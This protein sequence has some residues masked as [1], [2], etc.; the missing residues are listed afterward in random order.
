M[1]NHLLVGFAFIASALYGAG[2]LCAAES[3]PNTASPGQQPG[4]GAVR[5]THIDVDF[6]M[7]QLAPNVYAFISNNTTHD[8]EDGNT[9]VIIGDDA[10]A[11]VDAPSTYL[12]K[13]HLA[14]IRKLT[15]K[16]IRYLINT[17]FHRDHVLGNHVY[18]DANPDVIVIQ[19][20]Y[21]AMIANR[22]DPVAIQD[23]QGKN[24]DD[25]LHSLK[26]AAEKG[27]DAKGNALVGYDLERAKRSYQEFLPVYRE[28][29]GTRYVPANMTFKTALTINLGAC[30][31]QLMHL[32]GHTPGDTVVWIPKAS[33]LAAGDL[34]IAPVPYGGFDQY[35]DWIASLNKL[36]A[37][38]A[39]TIVPGHG[40]VEFTQ[41][42]MAQERDLFKALV[43]QAVAAVNQGHSFEEFK[44]SLDLSAFEAKFT[45]G[46]PELEWGW[47][48]YF[49][50]KNGAL[51]ARA[52][53]TAFGAL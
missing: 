8:W 21:T 14:Q 51:A 26:A 41:E 43:D 19:Q 27:V 15:N 47:N 13:R 9:T 44:R 1:K 38:N 18:K 12:S 20:E 35:L 29:K 50:N 37:F 10:V 4:S 16:P 53:R 24:G 33:I 45:H 11:V 48:N 5:V 23:L 34:V 25:Q 40:S 30:E 31:I 22:R 39:A 3:P 36:I 46:D 2:L 7:D 28:A 32:G 17:H 6:E 42:Y 49:N 52:Y